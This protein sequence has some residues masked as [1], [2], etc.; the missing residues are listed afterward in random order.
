MKH[1]I[2]Y[3]F[4][5]KSLLIGNKIIIQIKII[6]KHHENWVLTALLHAFNNSKSI[7]YL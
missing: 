2:I 6:S 7:W 1:M 4:L 5:K 3:I